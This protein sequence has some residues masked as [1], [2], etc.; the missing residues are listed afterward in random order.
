MMREPRLYTA[1]DLRIGL[2]AE[3]ER[4]IT[5]EDIATFADL[6]H[7][8]NPLHTDEEY[9]RRSN[10]GKRIAHG[11]FQVDWRRPWPACTFPAA[12]LWWAGFNAASLPLCST[13]REC[14][15]RAK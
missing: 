10:Y 9:A 15:C 4:D 6:S 14:A 5:A 2:Q 13:R 3:F 1:A 12:R 11:A 7:D 8:W